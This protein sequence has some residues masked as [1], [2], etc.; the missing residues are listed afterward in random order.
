[1]RNILCC[2]MASLILSVSAGAQQAADGAQDKRAPALVARALEK[3]GG[4]ALQKSGGLALE[5]E[6]VWDAAAELQGLR[7]NATNPV[8][9][10][11][12]LAPDFATDRLGYE[13]RH[14]RYDGTDDSLRFVYLNRN[15]MR[16][17]HLIDRFAFWR[18][19]DSFVEDRRRLARVIPHLLLAE[20]LEHP[21]S[22]RYL[23][24]RTIAGRKHESV[25]YRFSSGETLTLF[26]DRAQGWLRGFEQI[27]DMPL[28]GD[29]TVRWEFD[30]YRRL[31]DIGLY[32]TGYRIKLG[33]RLL[34]QMRYTQI[35]T[36]DVSESELFDVPAGIT[37][38]QPPAPTPAP[39]PNAPAAR[40][41]PPRVTP[42][43]P[44]VYFVANVRAGSHA[45][46]VE[47]SDSLMAFDAPAGYLELHQI[48]A[49]DF[50]R[51]ATSSSVSEALIR[52]MK[53]T[54]PGKPIRYLALTH[55]HSD[56][57]GGV[58]AFIAEGA[59]ILTTK[60]VRPLI[61]RAARAK[62]TLNPDRLSASAQAPKIE[63]ISGRREIS[64]GQ[65]AV[66]L[67][68]VGP[69]PHADEILV[70]HLPRDGIVF[71]ADLFQSWSLQRQPSRGHLALM[72]FFVNW[73]DTRGLKPVKIH[74]AHST[75]PATPE[76]L[77]RL[78]TQRD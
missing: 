58:R 2:L 1:M 25:S 11:E 18:Q 3:I 4:A 71:V 68:E 45:M 76:H 22:L 12:R 49:Q 41:S 72:R 24:A 23:G 53:E 36:A 57:A 52:V 69:N 51:G 28:L 46:F 13:S 66:E 27:V 55:F 78:R 50:A 9:F 16:F 17:A 65:Q 64:D 35:H 34:K 48:P 67:L 8:K 60:A 33:T 43:A 77:A 62:F 29:T 38:P 30:E 40:P 21:T 10:V 39:A 19:D 44:G 26:F 15:Q 56:H 73:L 31:P 5:A 32:P 75:T 47:F 54:V 70:A 7:P 42:I 37:P 20:M 6:G 74:S 14:A 59:T 61:E 63:I